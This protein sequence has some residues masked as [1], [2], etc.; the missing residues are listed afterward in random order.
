[1]NGQRAAEEPADDG[2]GGH[3]DGDLSCSQLRSVLRAGGLATALILVAPA[4]YGLA[5]VF[6]AMTGILPTLLVRS[7]LGIGLV[8]LFPGAFVYA[9]WLK[10]RSDGERSCGVPEYGVN[11]RWER[12]HL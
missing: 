1:M 8:A 9:R 2:D 12:E 11:D 6:P 5:T 3:H 10:R 7:L 4:Y